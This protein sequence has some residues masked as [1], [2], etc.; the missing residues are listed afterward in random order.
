[1]NILIKNTSFYTLGT[2]IPQ[3]AGFILLPIYSRFLLP[4]EYGIVN[5][6]AVLGV[7]IS[8][9]FS[10]CLERSIMRLYYDYNSEKDKKIFYGTIFIAMSGIG[11]ICLGLLFIF[12]KYV[13]SIYATIDFFPFYTYTI[14][15]SFVGSFS[16]MPKQQL[17]LKDKASTFVTLSLIQ[18][19]INTGLILYYIT[20][21]QT[22][23]LGYIQGNLIS[24]IVLLPVFIY[25]SLKFSILKFNFSY[26]KHALYYSLPLIPAIMGAWVLNLSDRIFIERYF[27]MT[28]VGLYSLGYKIAGIVTLLTASF[29]AAYTPIFF[30]LANSADQVTAKI[31][32]FKYNNIYLIFVILSCF[33]ISFFSREVIGLFFDINYHKAWIFVPL[34]SI[35]LLFSQA[36]MITSSS[37][38][39]SKKLKANMYI[40]MILV[41]LSIILNFILIPRFGPVGATITAIISMYL[42]FHI[43]YYYTKKN[44][45]FI[46]INWK[47]ISLITV[48]LAFTFI[49]F[50]Y[51]LSFNLIISLIVKCVF[52]GIIAIILTKI[53]FYEIRAIFIEKKI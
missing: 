49:L 45:Y 17:M 16:L 33:I 39:Q 21:K 28:D 27:N 29:S 8:I 19:I 24:Q 5:S 32:L 40:S 11:I 41:L 48:L 25:F 2:I 47:Q 4:S 15:A 30:R 38:Q 22:G 46:P 26:F 7:F 53:Y 43:S 20:I 51:L 50:Y 13:S 10:M 1:M 31:T 34:I 12:H 36:S 37:F 14:V 44:C 3:A 9:F 52:L 23:A 6:M 35:S 42:G 18:F